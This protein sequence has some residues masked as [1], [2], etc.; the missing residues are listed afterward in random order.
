MLPHWI[1]ET[2]FAGRLWRANGRAAVRRWWDERNANHLH[3]FSRQPPVV[4]CWWGRDDYALQATLRHQPLLLLYLFPWCTKLE[5]VPTIAAEIKKRRQRFPRHRHVFLCNEAGTVAPLRAAGVEAIF[6]NQNAFINENYFRPLPGAARE[7]DAVYNAA[8]SPYK[9]HQLAAQ[10]RSLLILTY[11]YAGTHRSAYEEAT[12]RV[13]AHAAW[14]KDSQ[15]DGGKVSPEQIT[16]FYNRAHVGL[17]LSGIEGAMFVS[18][19]YL[20]CGLPVVSTPSLGG[21]DVFWDDRFVL[22]CEPTPEKIAAA[23]QEL[24]ARRL[25]PQLIRA[26]TLE[27]VQQH[28]D[29][30][31]ELLAPIHADNFA[32]PWPPGS[33][34]PFTFTRLRDLGR[35]LSLGR[36]PP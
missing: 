24:K 22:V 13:L 16:A 32:C 5:D 28:R 4:Y 8:M 30:L 7:F 19:E 26:A 18:M 11:T 34:G 31:R 21:R 1:E 20:L 12:R 25:D 15:D 6:C 3:V 9:R 27:R 35:E 17:A 29:R 23:V 33:H 36:P 14:L 2:I 10:V